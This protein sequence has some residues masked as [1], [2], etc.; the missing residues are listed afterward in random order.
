MS[1]TVIVTEKKE[2]CSLIILY[3]VFLSMRIKRI[4]SVSAI[5]AS[6]L[7]LISLV[8]LCVRALQQEKALGVGREQERDGGGGRK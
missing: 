5:L 2:I 4:I 6:S 3:I 1:E 8:C 7:C